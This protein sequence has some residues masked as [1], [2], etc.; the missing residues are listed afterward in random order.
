MV[1]SPFLPEISSALGTINLFLDNA[2][3]LIDQSRTRVQCII[4]AILLLNLLK[5]LI[6]DHQNIRVAIDLDGTYLLLEVTTANFDVVN[7]G[8]HTR[9]DLCFEEGKIQFD[10]FLYDLIDSF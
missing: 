8:L 3:Y 5:E 2:G 4:K 1:S 6:P 10:V 9:G 7:D